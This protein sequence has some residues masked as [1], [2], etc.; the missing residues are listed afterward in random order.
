MGQQEDEA[1]RVAVG[2]GGASVRPTQALLQTRHP[3]KQ[4]SATDETPLQHTALTTTTLS[5][6]TYEASIDGSAVGGLAASRML[7]CEL[8][9]MS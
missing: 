8:R 6:P 1:E 5:A 7:A 3:Q 9:S 4:T 2:L